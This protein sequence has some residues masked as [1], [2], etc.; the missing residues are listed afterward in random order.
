MR[1]SKALIVL[2]VFCSV[3]A[4]KEVVTT[5][6]PGSLPQG[7]SSGDGTAA[8]AQVAGMTEVSLDQIPQ[9][10]ISVDIGACVGKD[11]WYDPTPGV[12]S[13]AGAISVSPTRNPKG[14]ASQPT[15]WVFDP[16]IEKAGDLVATKGLNKWRLDRADHSVEVIA[17]EVEAPSKKSTLNIP[18]FNFQSSNDVKYE[19]VGAWDEAN[20]SCSLSLKP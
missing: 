17:Y 3:P 20:K 14:D 7:A 15:P 6:A 13:K 9:V 5:N 2:S 4:C 16:T 1:F 11:R 12:K 10:T 8:T 18:T 19:V